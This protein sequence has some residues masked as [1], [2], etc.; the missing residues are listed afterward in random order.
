MVKLSSS[1][2]ALVALWCADKRLFSAVAL[3]CVGRALL[4][5]PFPDTLW[6][7]VFV[8]DRPCDVSCVDQMKSSS[9]LCCTRTLY[10]C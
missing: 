2:L 7:P 10:I 9:A 6:R 8:C 1:C 3:V 4:S 5:S